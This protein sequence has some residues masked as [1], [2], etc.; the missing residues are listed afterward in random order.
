MF[1]HDKAVAMGLKVGNAKTCKRCHNAESP[2][3]KGFDYATAVK[4]ISHPLAPF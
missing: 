1:K 3:F 4:K 2:T